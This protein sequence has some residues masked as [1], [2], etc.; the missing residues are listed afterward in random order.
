M[1]LRAHTARRAKGG[2]LRLRR[3][4]SGLPGLWRVATAS[5][6]PCGCRPGQKPLAS[7]TGFPR[8]VPTMPSTHCK[9]ASD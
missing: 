1:A 4:G 8:S 6:A 9:T 7:A 5:A 3:L 2:A